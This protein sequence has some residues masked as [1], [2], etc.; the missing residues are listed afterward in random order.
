LADLAAAGEFDDYEGREVELQVERI[1]DGVVVHAV[2]D[3]L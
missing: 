1:G 3:Q 2:D